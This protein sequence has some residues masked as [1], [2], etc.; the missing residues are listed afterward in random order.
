M[1]SIAEMRTNRVYKFSYD[2]KKRLAYFLEERR[3]A[4]PLFLCWDFTSNGYR[5]FQASKIDGDIVDVSQFCTRSYKEPKSD[6]RVRTY[7]HTDGF[8]YAVRF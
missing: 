7:K 4:D 5:Q 2:G 3:L 6:P 1:L 8:T